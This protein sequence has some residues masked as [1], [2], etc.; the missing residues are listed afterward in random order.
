MGLLDRASHSS[1]QL[2]GGMFLVRSSSILKNQSCKS[3]S[4]VSEILKVFLSTSAR[5]EASVQPTWKRTYL[6]DTL[7][8]TK[9]PWSPSLRPTWEQSSSREGP[10]PSPATKYPNP[11][12]FNWRCLIQRAPLCVS[13]QFHMILT[14]CLP[15]LE[16]FCDIAPFTKKVTNSDTS[17]N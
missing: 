15:I 1:F 2:S 11:D 5:W 16:H 8:R 17:F 7:L 9:T 3:D 10:S 12:S 14:T 4:A 13:S 6:C